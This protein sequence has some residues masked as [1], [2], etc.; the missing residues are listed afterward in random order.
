VSTSRSNFGCFKPDILGV[1]KIPFKPYSEEYITSS[2]PLPSE[3]QAWAQAR[4]KNSSLPP[5]LDSISGNGNES[6]QKHRPTQSLPPELAASIVG[7]GSSSGSGSEANRIAATGDA[8]HKTSA[9]EDESTRP[10]WS[11]YLTGEMKCSPEVAHFGIASEWCYLSGA[12]ETCGAW[13]GVVIIELRMAF[14]LMVDEGTI[15]METADEAVWDKAEEIPAV[16]DEFDNLSPLP[17]ISLSIIVP[18]SLP[19]R[20]AG[21]RHLDPTRIHANVAVSRPSSERIPIRTYPTRSAYPAHRQ[22]HTTKAG[23][24][25]GTCVIPR[26][27]WSTIIRFICLSAVFL[28]HFMTVIYPTSG[29]MLERS[30]CRSARLGIGCLRIVWRGRRRGRR[31][32]RRYTR[33]LR[34][35]L[36]GRRRGRSGRGMVRMVRVVVVVGVDGGVVVE[37]AGG[38]V[39]EEAGNLVMAESRVEVDPVGIKVLMGRMMVE[40][41]MG[42]AAEM[43]GRG[44]TTAREGIRFRP[45]GKSGSTSTGIKVIRTKTQT[46]SKNEVTG[47]GSS[48][49]LSAVRLLSVVRV[50]CLLAFLR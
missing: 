39:V 35:V 31:G 18:L 46:K 29:T 14:C 43:G 28:T 25:S 27:A 2:L 9:G 1:A 22:K 38:V 20:C 16:S 17:P 40:G 4:I 11:A 15:V 23:S 41:K 6:G 12:Y 8:P 50:R 30:E 24:N 26:S 21:L 44:A 5:R 3:G 37:E 33:G 13:I 7:N 48:I 45:M 36:G 19:V 32:W 10:W 42:G 34:T 47:S 49:L